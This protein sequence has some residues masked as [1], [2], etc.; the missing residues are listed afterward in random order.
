MRTTLEIRDSCI[1]SYATFGILTH[2]T[3]LFY[4]V[5]LEKSVRCC[6]TS[7]DAFSSRMSFL[8]PGG[9]MNHVEIASIRSLEGPKYQEG[10][11][12][13]LL[14]GSLDRRRIRRKLE[15]ES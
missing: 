6:S 5:R 9:C 15:W 3:P 1:L 12:E 11:E 14:N 7:E 10:L 4:L 13:D 8:N 2:Q